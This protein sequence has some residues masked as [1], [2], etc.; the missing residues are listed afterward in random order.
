MSVKA[1][2]VS[3]G[4]LSSSDSEGMFSLHSRYYDNISRKKFSDDLSAKQWVILLRAESGALS[5]FST[6]Q[7]ISLDIGG[8]LHRFLFSGNTVVEENSRMSH[9]L[10]GSFGHVMMM[11]MDKY[12]AGSIHWFLISKGF[13]SY[14]FL[15]VFFRKF[16]PRFD[17]DIPESC[18]KL[19][20][21]V[22][23]AQ[24]GRKYDSG[25]NIIRMNGETDWLKPEHAAIPPGRLNDPHVDFFVSANPG[26]GTGDELAC[27]ADIDPGNLNENAL[28][29][30]KSTRVE[31]DV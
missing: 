25:K 1:A 4:K 30:I 18:S 16:Y 29:V 19:I 13:R 7:L 5:G 14:R 24:F 11:L 23:F 21:A 10:A 8:V 6:L 9:A 27:L 26:Y 15:P 28:R 17:Q 2:I 22:S 31:W 20:A 3:I 12:D